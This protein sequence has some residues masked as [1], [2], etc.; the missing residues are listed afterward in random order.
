MKTAP[1]SHSLAVAGAVLLAVLVSTPARAQNTAFTYQ[2][3]LDDANQPTNGPHDFRFLLLDAASGG[4]QLGSTLCVDNVDVVNGVFTAQLDFGQQFATTAPRHLEIEVRADTG[5]DC[6]NAA[7]FVGLAPRQ[8][9]TSTPMASHANA[10]FSLDAADGSP[11][12]AVFVDDSG[13]V[14]IGTTTPGVPLHLI[15]P[16]TGSTPREGIRIQGDQSTGAN[17]AYLSFANGAG[18]AIG[19]VGD[20]G[21]SE[22][23]IYL[24]AYGADIGLV[25]STY[26][27]VLT[28]KSTGLV[29]IGTATP[30]AKLDVR[31]DVKLGPAGQYF[32]ASADENLRTIRGTANGNGTIGFGSGWTVARTAAGSHTVFFSTPFSDRPSVVA[33]HGN[34]TRSVAVATPVQGNVAIRIYNS[35]GVLTDD[36]FYFIAT[37][38]R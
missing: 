23:N 29:G 25:N 3:L 17:L 37:G 7:G 6:T 12:S 27:T 21:G 38:P 13:K 15:A 36:V 14:G 19:Y 20:G 18:T 9:I 28:A 34:S 16:N 2:G 11:A 35:A 10:A 33:S 24:G 8:Q 22:N 5:L 4:A 30:A 26:G 32:A 31:G 1:R